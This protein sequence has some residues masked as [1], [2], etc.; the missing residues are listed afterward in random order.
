[1]LE[2]V[3]LENSVFEDAIERE[4]E[5][6]DACCVAAREDPSRGVCRDDF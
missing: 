6:K 5:R 3:S 1:M 2:G 4:N